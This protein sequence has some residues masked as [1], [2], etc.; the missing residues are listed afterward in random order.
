MKDQHERGE[1][2]AAW[3]RGLGREATR[4]HLLRLSAGLVVSA[5]GLA[6]A[7]RVAAQ[8]GTPEAEADPVADPVADPEAGEGGTPSAGAAGTPS[9]TG[10]NLVVYSGRSENLVGPLISRFEQETGIA[11]EVRYAGTPEL[12]TTLLEEGDATPADVFFAQDAGSLGLVAQE[13]LFAELPADLLDRVDPRFRDP[14]GRWVGTSG[15][16][17]VLVYNTDQLADAD[18][19]ASVFDL[20]D[21]SWR[22]RVGWA[23]ENASFLAFV[24]ALR[25]LE[26]DEAARAWLEGMLAN[27]VQNYA[28]SN[29]AI[30]RAVGAGEIEVGLV[31]HY[32]L[33]AVKED[34]GADFPIANHYFAAGDPGSLVNVTGAGILASAANPDQARRFVDYLLAESAQT[35]FAEETSEYPLVEGVPTVEGL[36]PLA[37][38]G[39][40]EI[41]LSDLA[42]L[43]GTLELLA[44]VGVV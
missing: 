14:Q 19:P 37:E 8:A 32:Y 7:R 11:V 20:T 21:E 12:A 39:S 28:D 2:T 31:N 17:R 5:G 4:R 33:Y 9:G 16:A 24:T 25:V 26:G 18:L 38:V 6:G 40:P 13:G 34:E 30:V 3:D 42:D 22:G 35:Y 27:D 10:G 23:P 36:R 29:T 15:R 43:R 41:D 1:D 44:D